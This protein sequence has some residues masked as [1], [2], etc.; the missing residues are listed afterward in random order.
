[1]KKST[2]S[3][4]LALGALILCTFGAYEKASAISTTFTSK[5]GGGKAITQYSLRGFDTASTKKKVWKVTELSLTPSFSTVIQARTDSFMLSPLDTVISRT[6][7]LFTSVDTTRD[8]YVRVRAYQSDSAMTS[9]DT[10]TGL[11]WVPVTLKPVEIKPRILTAVLINAI[12]QPVVVVDYRSWDTLSVKYRISYGDTSFSFPYNYKNKL[13]PGN[14]TQTNTDTLPWMPKNY[15]YS[16]T[17]QILNTKGDT[18]T[19]VLYNRTLSDSAAATVGSIKSLIASADSIKFSVPVV[20]NG[21]TTTVTSY[22]KKGIVTDSVMQVIPGQGG[23]T[24]VNVAMGARTPATT[25]TVWIGAKNSLNI[26]PA[27]SNTAM[28]TTKSLVTKFMPSLDSAVVK[29]STSMD[30]HI[31][32][33]VPAGD[34]GNVYALVNLAPD[35]LF[36]GPVYHQTETIGTE[37]GPGVHTFVLSVKNVPYGQKFYVAL[38]GDNK[39]ASVVHEVGDIVKSFTLKFPPLATTVKNVIDGF[40][41]EIHPNPIASHAVIAVDDSRG[42]MCTITDMTGRS[43][44]TFPLEGS[45][46][47]FARGDMP[48]GM[49]ILNLVKDGQKV[50]FKRIIIE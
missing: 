46:T 9:I 32:V 19:T 33:T 10:A 36:P 4:V 44:K 30:V 50:G 26:T 18:T 23:V 38:F 42:I 14:G 27:L 25:Y 11:N 48:S 17:V 29:D 3:A 13:I 47:T 24:I 31:T 39:D 21:L 43:I 15:A 35:S 2:V 12:N 7:T 28:I 41:F 37:I 45:R 34:K 5:N 6:D 8:Y 22:F 49:Y 1:M 20:T 40:S 16:L